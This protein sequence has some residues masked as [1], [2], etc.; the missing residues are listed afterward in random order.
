MGHLRLQSIK[1]KKL[2]FEK[3]VSFVK[4][5]LRAVKV[6]LASLTANLAVG[7]GFPVFQ[8]LFNMYCSSRKGYKNET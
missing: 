5:F 8:G 1:T 6:V 7:R 2:Q 4:Y 3:I